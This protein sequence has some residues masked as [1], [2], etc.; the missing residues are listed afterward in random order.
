MRYPMLSSWVTFKDYRYG[1]VTVKNELTGKTFLIRPE[2][3]EFLQMLDGRTNPYEMQYC[4]EMG[5]T[6]TDVYIMLD[7]FAFQGLV[8]ESRTYHKS[9]TSIYRTVWLPKTTQTDAPLPRILNRML[10]TLF[11]PVFL[12]GL[13][14]YV[15]NAGSFRVE[16]LSFWGF[17][18]GALAGLFLGGVVHEC[19]HVIAGLAYGGKVYEAG[20]SLEHLFFPGA[21]SV[22]QEEESLT[23]IRKVQGA[24]AGIEANLLAAGLALAA[25]ALGLRLHGALTFFAIVN[26]FLV[27]D[28][29]MFI[30]GN[31][32]CQIY[33]RIYG[34]DT[35]IA[36]AARVSMSTEKNRLRILQKGC[37]GK[38]EFCTYCIFLLL[39]LAGIV[40]A[41][42]CI[43]EVIS[44]IV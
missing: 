36:D 25:A 35:C 6:C 38:A 44:W 31:D 28:N 13:I 24:A 20:V 27:F 41:V 19:G 37:A 18:V 8:R 22:V 1:T 9:S 16:D 32:G 42:T 3:A 10:W 5:W 2:H 40:L 7:E 4:M 33:S 14:A 39:Q 15:S 12:C 30:S 29:L 11:L 21:Y 26:I 43:V 17:I 23:P 34:L